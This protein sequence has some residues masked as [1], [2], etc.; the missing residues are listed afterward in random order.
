MPDPG[1]AHAVFDGWRRWRIAGDGGFVGLIGDVYCYPPTAA[2][3]QL[4]VGIATLPQHANRIGNLH[5]GFLMAF[6][7]V[8]LFAVLS[9]GDPEAAP[10]VTVHCATDFLAIGQV[11]PPLEA[12]GRVVHETGRLAFLEGMLWQHDKPIVRWNG[13]MRRIRLA[14]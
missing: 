10:A 5:G 8:A 3:P 4:R 11:G 12:A 2:D 14:P 6:V 1:S 9:G 13:I 7:D